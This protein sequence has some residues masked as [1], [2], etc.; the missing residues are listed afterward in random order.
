[1]YKY[2]IKVYI[3]LFR[4]KK[5]PNPDEY[6]TVPLGI[7]TI[8]ELSNYNVAFSNFEFRSGLSTG[9]PFTSSLYSITNATGGGGS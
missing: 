2:Y 8:S 1:M 9:N 3:Y 6:F 5:R 7:I 4:D